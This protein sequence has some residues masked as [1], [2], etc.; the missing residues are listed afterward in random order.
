M[1]DTY[2]YKNG[3]AMNNSNSTFVPVFKALA[4]ETRL[5]I[6]DMLSAGELCACKILEEFQFTQPT[7]SY[8]MKILTESGLVTG[9]RA[10]AWM[11]Y[12]LNADTE[13]KLKLFLDRLFA[14]KS[15]DIERVNDECH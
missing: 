2:L 11:R 10:G 4:D 13:A 15:S 5:K 14:G 8:H 9:V 1:I 7:L 12:S 3:D 6:I